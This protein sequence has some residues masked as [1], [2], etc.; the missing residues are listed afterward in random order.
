MAWF[1]VDDQMYDHPK[2]TSLSL[3]TIGLWT[4]GGSYCARHLTDGFLP[5]T[6]TPLLRPESSGGRAELVA[7]GLWDEVDGGVRFHDW[8]E[9][10]PTRESVLAERAASKERQRRA[11]EAAKSRRESQGSH[12]VTSDEVTDQSRRESRSPRPDPTRPV[13]PKGTTGAAPA[14]PPEASH[15]CNLLADLIEANGSK[16]PEVTQRWLDSARLMLQRDNRDVEQ[17]EHLIRWAQA[18]EFWR[19]NILSMPK[20][21]EKYDQLRLQEL[22]AP[23][24]TIRPQRSDATGERAIWEQAQAHAAGRP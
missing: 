19:P 23:V 1:K 2:F 12:G 17:A 5:N 9:Y 16:R 14:A 21:R 15:L 11:R 7:A 22:T 8:L 20:F 4:A 13:V 3:A 24:T 10:Q 18:S 6:A